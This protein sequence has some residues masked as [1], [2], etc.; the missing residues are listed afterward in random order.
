[1]TATLKNGQL[2]FYTSDQYDEHMIPPN[3][4]IAQ[5]HQLAC[6]VGIPNPYKEGETV[7]ICPCC[8]QQIHKTQIDLQRDEMAFSFLGSGYPL[9]FNFIKCCL[10][11]VGVLFLTSGQYQLVSNL[12]SNDCEDLVVQVQHQYKEVQKQDSW[13]EQ[14]HNYCLNDWIA[15]SSL[16]NKRFQTILTQLPHY[17]NFSSVIFILVIIFFFRK[18][19]LII[20]NDC[21]IKENTPSDYTLI[22]KD[23]P[24]D[25]KQQQL[26]EFFEKKFEVEVMEIDYIFYANTLKDMELELE[27]I[28]KLQKIALEKNDND[29]LL[30]LNE[31]KKQKQNQITAEAL[32]IQSDF[33]LFSG[34]AFLSLKYEDHKQIILKSSNYRTKQVI[35]NIFFGCIIQEA[36]SLELNDTFIKV[37]QAPEPGDVIWDNIVHNDNRRFWVRLLGFTFSQIVI[38][39]FLITLLEL[40]KI[41]AKD[42]SNVPATLVD[43]ETDQGVN[44]SSMIA[45]LLTTF[46]NSFVVGR[47]S[48]FLVGFE[49]YETYSLYTVSL[50]SKLS[51]MLFV[52]SAIIAFLASTIYTRNL[53]GPGGLIYTETYFFMT[54]AIIPPIV[55]LVDPNRIVKSLKLWW[56]K[57]FNKAVTQKELNSLYEH[58]EHMIEL[59]YADIMKTLFITFFYTPLTPAGYITSF[60]GLALYYGAE[61]YVI[62]NR[63]TV[64]HTPSVQLSILMTEMM[65]YLPIIYAAGYLIFNYQITG[66]TSYWAIASILISFL[67]SVLPMQYFVESCFKQEEQDE[68][69]SYNEAKVNF[70]T[71]YSLQN[72]VNKY[73]KEEQV[74]KSQIKSKSQS[75]L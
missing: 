8:K 21:D 33:D 72:P 20:D 5:Q 15:R 19:Q 13:K 70:S 24:K 23:I 51:L 11:I 34:T 50:A 29:Q 55:T 75:Q 40:A 26:K 59:K 4:T 12:T 25:C 30:N 69:T 16:A 42:A 17:F 64:K 71:T 62:C 2:E 46:I 56:I 65:E 32:R 61:K 27:E 66:S 74:I 9:Y 52:N 36:K 58:S 53:F 47:L 67:S 18:S 48:N 43:V 1:M 3:Y 73:N 28:V 39:L 63:M 44:M 14:V 41:Q 60:V 68:T 57:K 35:S 22:V 7:N 54:N 49:S 45:A 37:D 6:K 31:Q 10:M 38:A